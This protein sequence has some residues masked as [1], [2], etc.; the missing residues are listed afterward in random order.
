M[1]ALTM[2]FASTACLTVSLRSHTGAPLSACP[3]WHDGMNINN[4]LCFVWV[5]GRRPARLLKAP[6]AY[7]A[8]P[9]RPI[10][11]DTASAAIAYPALDARV[12]K[13]D[14]KAAAAGSSMLS[15]LFS[16]RR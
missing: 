14:K 4:C 10:M 1:L 5:V 16:W 7:A 11:L 9:V 13:S 2:L 12:G 3:P 15:S 6:Y 8:V